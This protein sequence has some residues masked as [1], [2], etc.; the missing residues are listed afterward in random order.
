MMGS[1]SSKPTRSTTARSSSVLQGS[2]NKSMKN[3]AGPSATSPNGP[4]ADSKL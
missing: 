2:R 3:S 1:T 4:V